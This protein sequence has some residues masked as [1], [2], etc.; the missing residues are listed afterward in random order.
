MVM[1]VKVCANFC[2]SRM[3][4]LQNHEHDLR[5]V[6]PASKSVSCQRFTMQDCRILFSFCL[7]FLRLL[8]TSKGGLKEVGEFLA[9]NVRF[10]RTDTILA[11]LNRL[12]V[13]AV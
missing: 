1:M 5:S 2:K 8:C 4:Y 7:L 6:R 9:V 11:T 13:I 10:G 3:L 12:D